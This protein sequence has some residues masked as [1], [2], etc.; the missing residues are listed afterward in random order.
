M[1]NYLSW[2]QA[3][4][5]INK[6]YK[7]KQHVYSFMI[8]LGINTSLK[9]AEMLPLKWN[10]FIYDRVAV[11]NKDGISVKDAINIKGRDIYLNNRAKKHIVTL[12]GIIY[13]SGANKLEDEIFVDANGVRLN[14][15]KISKD[16]KKFESKY[17][18]PFSIGSSSLRLTFASRVIEKFGQSNYTLAFLKDILGQTSHDEVLNILGFKVASIELEMKT[19]VG[20]LA[21]AGS[22]NLEIGQENQ[23]LN[24][25]NKIQENHNNLSSEELFRMYQELGELN[26]FKP[27]GINPNPFLSSKEDLIK[28]TQLRIE[29]LKELSK[30]FKSDETNK[31]STK[32]EIK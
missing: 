7:D 18:L 5:L 32:G 4:D 25:Y 8:D 2:Q 21:D 22:S 3:N 6:L 28:A 11:Q 16:F 29:N 26:K 15:P 9:I 10:D 1:E 27:Y 12:F 20:M 17:E 19:V 23:Y 14:P 13:K 24:L 31:H 30:N